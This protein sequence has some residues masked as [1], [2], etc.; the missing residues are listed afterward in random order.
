M[1]PVRLEMNGFAAFRAPT[2]VD[3]AMTQTVNVSS[4]PTRD[5][6]GTRPTASGT[7]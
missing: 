4:A 3:N 7:R 2:C 5:G 6:I 1:R